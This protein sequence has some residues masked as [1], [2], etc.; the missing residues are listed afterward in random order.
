MFSDEDALQSVK[1]TDSYFQSA[2]VH[3]YVKRIFIV[4]LLNIAELNM[5]FSG[6]NIC[7]FLAYPL[8]LL[9]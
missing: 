4:M 2:I 3:P 8:L 5:P 9:E 1:K 6:S 7:I